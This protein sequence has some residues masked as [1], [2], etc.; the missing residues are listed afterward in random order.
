MEEHF[1]TMEHTFMTIHNLSAEANILFSSDSI[2]EILGYQPHEVQGR[3][4]FDYFHPDEVPFARTVHSRGV[5]L[6]KAASLHYVRVQSRDGQWISCECCFTVVHDV[7]VACTSIYRRGSKS[8]RRAIDAPQIR[9][10][11]S[12]SPR[13]PR[14]HMLEHLSPKFKMTPVEREPRA[15]LILNRFTRPLSIMYATDAVAQI[16]GL[17]P[18]QLQNKSFYQCI[19]DNC[20]ADAVRCLESAKSNDSIAYLRFWFRDPRTLEDFGIEEDGEVDGHAGGGSPSSS[21]SDGGAQLATPMDIDSEEPVVKTEPRSPDVS[22]AEPMQTATGESSASSGAPVG[23]V[24]EGLSYQAS[25]SGQSPP[26]PAADQGAQNGNAHRPEPIATFELEAVVSCT[27]DGLVVILR[28]A[29]PPIPTAYPPSLH[30]GFQNGLFAAPWGEQPIQPYYPPENYHR[31]SPPLLPEYMPLQEHVKAAG[32][33]PVDQLMRSIRDVAVF[34]WA[35]VGINGNL[36]SHCH[37]IPQ[38]E[39]QPDGL[40][41]WDPNAGKTSYLGPENQASRRWSRPAISD[42]KGKGIAHST[43]MNMDGFAGADHYGIATAGPSTTT[44]SYSHSSWTNAGQDGHGLGGPIYQQPQYSSHML[45]RSE[46]YTAQGPWAEAGANEAQQHNG[47]QGI[48]TTQP[49]NA[50]DGQPSSRNLWQ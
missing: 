22:S 5:R 15:A 23:V 19:A 34:A 30:T 32:G 18:E 26:Q 42:G 9:R 38:G 21:D 16:L 7:L 28:R 46:A 20:L 2:A 27:S 12:S 29:R 41:I 10:I 49:S 1:G 25:H 31:F 47:N 17:R 48:P 45:P 3:S 39:A 13:D 14:Y 36:A 37:G 8:Q 40:P 11:F 44:Q 6:D 43:G 50:E 4:C 35:L 33:P 24:P